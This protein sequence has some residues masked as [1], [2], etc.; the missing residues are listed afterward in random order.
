MDI[1]DNNE[2]DVPLSTNKFKVYLSYLAAENEGG[3]DI[4]LSGVLTLTGLGGTAL[5]INIYGVGIQTFRNGNPAQYF[6]V[7][8]DFVT[9]ALAVTGY[10]TYD[11]LYDAANGAWTGP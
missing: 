8:E 5:T 4:G 9:A 6:G 7:A 10:W 2:F 11:G 1:G 3:A